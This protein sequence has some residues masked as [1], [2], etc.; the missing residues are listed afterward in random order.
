M[1]ERLIIRAL[2]KG[3][4]DLIDDPRRIDVLFTCAL[5]LD[6]AEAQKAREIFLEK[7]PTVQFQYPR[8]NPEFPLYAVVLNS[9]TEEQHAL[10]DFG[11]FLGDSD[12]ATQVV[13]IG[14]LTEA[15]IIR[16][17]T[18]SH[19]FAI[20]TY[21][22]HPDVTLYLYYIAKQILIR[23]RD[24]FKEQGVLDISFGG[25]DMGPD[26]NYAPEWVFVRALTMQARREF[27][28]YDDTGEIVRSVE[29]SVDP[30][31]DFDDC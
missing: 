6:A 1:I 26:E 24:F 22:R 3:I 23:E 28:V 14:G 31:T 5:D 20:M 13:G 29:T 8:K 11:G 30:L 7:P 15:T 18:W 4:Q 16:T 2:K 19:N 27:Q 12:A 10:G 21:S 25:R 17:S 9:E